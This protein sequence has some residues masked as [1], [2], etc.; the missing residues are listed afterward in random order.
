MKTTTKWLMAVGALAAAGVLAV[1]GVVAGWFVLG[2]VSPTLRSL[3]KYSIEQT[4]SERA[5][6]RRTTVH[7]ESADY[8]RDFEDAPIWLAY[9]VPTNVIGRAPFGSALVCSIPGQDP[10]NYIAVDC[11]S[12]M[13]AY[14]VFRN[15]KHPPFDWRQAT[16]QAMESAG[17]M[18]HAERKRITDAALI[19]DVVRTL[20]DGTPTPAGELPGALTRPQPP[21]AVENMCRLQ[22]YSDDLP[23]LAF[24]PMLFRG[25]TGSVYLAESIGVEYTNRTQQMHA[26]WIPASE[27]FAQWLNTP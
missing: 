23:G 27:S 4:D 2:R 7:F 24:C 18:M 10:A 11:G 14:E 25:E 1:A 17:L 3:P 26:N 12:E 22:L 5:W 21:G 16:F 20:R 19:A 8:V 6:H 13:E 9:P 15:V